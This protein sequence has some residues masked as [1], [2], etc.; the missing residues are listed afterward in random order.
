MKTQRKSYTH[1]EALLVLTDW[2]R[3]NKMTQ[4]RFM[5][6]LAVR[7]LIISPQT[8][9]ALANGRITPG[10]KFRSVFKEITGIGLHAGFVEEN[11]KE[12][13]R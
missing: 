7:G 9:S 8:C 12:S 2:L 1:N 10:P 6:F 4:K 3:D 13:S 5:N 11:S